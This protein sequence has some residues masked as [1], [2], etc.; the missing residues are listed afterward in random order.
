MRRVGELC[1]QKSHYLFNEL[2]KLQG[3]SAVYAT[4]FFKEFVVRLPIN[5]TVAVQKLVS[6]GILAGVAVS[7]LM[8]GDPNLLLICVTEMRAKDELDRYVGCLGRL[9]GEV[10]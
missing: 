1:F 10:L 3:V 7:T 9:I 2:T 8:E 5:A 6:K 4:P